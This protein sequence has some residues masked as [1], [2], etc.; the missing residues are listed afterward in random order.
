MP[1]TRQY[2][3]YVAAES[4]GV[5]CSKKCNVLVIERRVNRKYELRV[6]APALE[7]VIIWDLRREEKVRSRDA[8]N[9]RM[10]IRVK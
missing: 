1:L 7:N 3:R 10:C 4:F 5:L 8:S 2:L 6:V 9:V